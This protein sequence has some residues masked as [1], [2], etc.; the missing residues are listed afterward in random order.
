MEPCYIYGMVEK[1]STNAVEWANNLTV[2]DTVNMV[3]ILVTTITVLILVVRTFR[4]KPSV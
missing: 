2:S 1:E 4:N 3:L